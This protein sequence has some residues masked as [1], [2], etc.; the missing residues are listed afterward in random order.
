MTQLICGCIY[1]G[2][3]KSS[4]ESFSQRQFKSNN[5]PPTSIFQPRDTIPPTITISSEASK[6]IVGE[7]ALINFQLSENSSDFTSTDINV[8]GGSLSNFKGTGSQY[9]AIFSPTANEITTKASLNIPSNAFTDPARNF[10]QD[11]N[12]SNNRILITVVP[13]DYECDGYMHTSFF[14][15]NVP[16]KI[17]IHGGMKE[18]ESLTWR[19]ANFESESE[20][21]TMGPP[22]HHNFGHKNAEGQIVER[23]SDKILS[24]FWH[25]AGT[26]DLEKCEFVW[27]PEGNALEMLKG[28]LPFF[29]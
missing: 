20:T 11:G 4:T 12:E 3:N 17:I 24:Y 16:I 21:Y 26:I 15:S 7:T 8:E 19:W 29:L 2:R 1:T 23:K 28:L 5:P 27:D 6:L 14:Q 18:G 10:N 13:Q 25:G 9:T 22:T